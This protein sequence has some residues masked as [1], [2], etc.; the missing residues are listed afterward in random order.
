V[1]S[2]EE[3]IAIGLSGRRCVL[4]RAWDIRKARPYAAYAEMDF[5]VPLGENGDTYDR[6]PGADGRDAPVG[7]IVKQAIENLPDDQ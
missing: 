1:I 4:G 5:D 2:G 6:Y 3:A 7:R